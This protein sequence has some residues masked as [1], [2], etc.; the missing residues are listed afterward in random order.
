MTIL[1]KMYQ[2]IEKCFLHVYSGTYVGEV[3]PRVETIGE[4][5]R[6]VQM[7]PTLQA[8]KEKYLSSATRPS[9]HA[10]VFEETKI[11]DGVEIKRKDHSLTFYGV[12]KIWNFQEFGDTIVSILEKDGKSIKRKG[13]CSN[14][15]M[16]QYA[17]GLVQG[18]VNTLSP[19]FLTDYWNYA[20]LYGMEGLRDFGLQANLPLALAHLPT[21][22]ALEEHF[23]IK[24]PKKYHRHNAENW[25][26]LP[27]VNLV[28]KVNAP[29]MLNSWL[30]FAE[31]TKS[32]GTTFVL[33]LLKHVFKQD[34]NWVMDYLRLC[35][36]TRQKP[37]IVGT[38]K[39]KQQLIE[40]DLKKKCVIKVDKFWVDFSKKLPNWELI[41]DGKRLYHEGQTQQHCVF[42]H[43]H[44]INSGKFAV[45]HRDGITIELGKA[46]DGQIGIVEARGKQN[47][48]PDADA[49]TKI[50]AEISEALGYDYGFLVDGDE[51][52][53]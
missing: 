35:K 23:G 33:A 1:S 31:Q 32:T 40:I 30:S 29:N 44:K 46:K 19:C 26:L 6:A 21:A 52:P 16:A 17:G 53:F 14:L 2:I 24:L 43:R 28:H 8:F 4:P 25:R 36:E 37:T 11:E 41:Q 47:R 10:M 42:S 3:K 45:F 39:H 51:L 49:Q 13:F 48:T 12:S 27:V 15:Y 50:I 7:T 38:K 9:V 20:A 34:I 22:K 5:L 18:I